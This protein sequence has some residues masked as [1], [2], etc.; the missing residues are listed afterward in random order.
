MSAEAASKAKDAFNKA[1]ASL[2]KLG[3]NVK[4]AV[5]NLVKSGKDMA[6]KMENMT[7]K[8]V[9]AIIATLSGEAKKGVKI[10]G[11]AAKDAMSKI[12][13][14]DAWGEVSA[15][16]ADKFAEAGD[17][18]EGLKTSDIVKVAK[19]EFAAGV[20]NF[21]KVKTWAKDQATELA[22]KFKETIP[23]LATAVKADID[24]VKGFLNGL[25][26]TDLEKITQDTFNQAKSS[27]KE[28]CD[29]I[30]AFDATQLKE[31][32]DKVKASAGDLATMTKAKAEEFGS[33]LGTLDVQDLKDLAADAKAAITAEAA[34]LMGG[35]KAAAAF[36]KDDFAKMT[37]Q[38]KEAFNGAD[39]KALLDGAGANA[40]EIFKELLNG[41]TVCPGAIS[42]ITVLHDPAVESAEDIKKKI[43]DAL[44]AAAN[45]GN[46]VISVVQDSMLASSAAAT[47]RRLSGTSS[48]DAQTVVRIESDSEALGN[49]NGDA[50]ATATGGTKTVTANPSGAASGGGASGGGASGSAKYRGDTR[51]VWSP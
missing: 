27:F 47:G 48:G 50:A 7:G 17:L 31:I 24:K 12:Q 18:L 43:T 36:T 8:D 34:K 29:K 13:S 28:A 21:G 9:E 39:F 3:G 22:K 19:D 1:S 30:G 23:D 4:D 45:T 51:M 32:K 11:D 37:K 41:C 40:G 44:S 10:A 15:W 20:E 5:D 42:D 14:S 33:L 35:A 46:T 6:S 2:T 38:A 49:K 16:T 25:N 26:A